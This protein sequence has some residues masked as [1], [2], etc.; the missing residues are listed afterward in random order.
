L[1]NELGYSAH[2]FI[3]YDISDT[4]NVKTQRNS[5]ILRNVEYLI[6]AVIEV[7]GSA[8]RPGE[9]F[10]IAKYQGMFERRV[11]AGQCFH[12]PY[13]GCREYPCDFEWAAGSEP[14]P[15]TES[16]GMIFREFDFSPVWKH[17]PAGAVRPQTWNQ[18]VAPLPQRG[19]LAQAVNG[20]IAVPEDF[21]AD[22]GEGSN[23]D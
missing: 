4:N 11:T 17:W 9:P 19:F 15:I 23:R 1:R 22:N 10:L 12:R 6:E 3:G 5:L 14:A 16:F 21:H 18:A 2:N 7:P 13:L 8:R 20:W